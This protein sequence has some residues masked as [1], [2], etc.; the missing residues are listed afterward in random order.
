VK[1]DVLTL[2]NMEIPESIVYD[3]TLDKVYYTSDVAGTL[4]EIVA[5]VAT[6]VHEGDPP[7]YT[8]LY[9][10][11]GLGSDLYGLAEIGRL[12]KYG[13]TVEFC[14]AVADFSGKSVR[15]AF[16]DVLG[17]FHLVA[18]ING[19][20]AKV[21][22]RTNGSGVLNSTGYTA[23][24][25]ISEGSD[26]TV[27]T[28]QKCFIVRVSNSSGSTAYDGTS[29]DASAL[30]T[31]H[32]VDLTSEL[33]HPLILDEVALKLWHFFGVD[34]PVYTIPLDAYPSIEYEPFDAVALSLGSTKIGVSGVYGVLVATGIDKNGTMIFEVMT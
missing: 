28:L 13:D 26:I 25:T 10:F 6:K 23:S 34:R 32:S 9:G 30:S 22:Q 4:Y 29:W 31:S 14:S 20:S 17:A 18:T 16:N 11:A 24:V 1:T 2:G 7:T 27:K 5:N 15:D 12:Y 8:R 3:P 33:I 21:Y 19:K